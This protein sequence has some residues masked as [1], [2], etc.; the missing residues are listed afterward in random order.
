MKLYAKIK[1]ARGSIL[2]KGDNKFITVDLL[3]EQEELK[4]S[5][6]FGI[7]S[8]GNY[9]VDMQDLTDKR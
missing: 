5:V 6:Y 2:G 7:D 3:G 9:I 4:A 8:R 1:T